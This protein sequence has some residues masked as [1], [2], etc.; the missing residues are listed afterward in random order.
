MNSLLFKFLF[1]RS[2]SLILVEERLEDK[3][4]S[5]SQMYLHLN[6]RATNILFNLTAAY[7]NTQ[8]QFLFRTVYLRG[9]KEKYIL[10]NT[11]AAENEAFSSVLKKSINIST[12]RLKFAL[13]HQLSASP[14]QKSSLRASIRHKSLQLTTKKERR[15]GR[16]QP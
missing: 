4:P 15:S 9:G 2:D 6:T 8:K 13:I 12:N 16:T 5:S 14:I 10:T 1:S 11:N 7:L 3:T